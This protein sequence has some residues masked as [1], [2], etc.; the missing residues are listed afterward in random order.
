MTTVREQF[1]LAAVAAY[2]PKGLPDASDIWKIDSAEL[3]GIEV[4]VENQ[5]HRR[6]TNVVWAATDD[7][8]LRNGGIEF[9]SR[10]IPAM[11]A[12]GALKNLLQDGLD[13]DCCFS[14]RTSV[15]VHLNMQDVQTE[16]V[17][18]LLLVYSLFEK[19]LFRYVGKARWRNIYCTPITETTLL[20]GVANRGVRTA[21]EKYTGFNLLPLQ[22]KGTVEFRHM[23][24]TVDVKK[25]CVWVDMIVRLKHYVMNNKTEDIRRTIIG[26][27]GGQI[28]A[29][30]EQVFGNLFEYLQISD[31]S[32]VMSRLAPIKMSMMKES[33]MHSQIMKMRNLKSKFFSI[34]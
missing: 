27:N 31:P 12:P 29:L 30:G 21:W 9:I 33:P 19:A 4:E 5:A 16:K 13:G 1:E 28:H 8:S 34:K 6:P 14:P 10:P 11:Y 2:V 18:D 20:S 22:Q 26:F 23:H 15:H 24:G 32:E 25:L 7:G 3:I 17:I